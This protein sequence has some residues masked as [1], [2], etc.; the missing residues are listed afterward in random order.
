M[1]PRRSALAAVPVGVLVTMT[2]CGGG[3]EAGRAATTSLPPVATT[4]RSATT[5]RAHPST[6]PPRPTS[7]TTASRLSAA[8]RLGFEGVGPGRLG[9][10]V[11]EA[12]R[13][14]GVPMRVKGG[15]YC[16]VVE[17][18]GDPVGVHFIVTQGERLDVIEVD[19]GPIA[20]QAGVRAGSTEDEA[21]RAHPGIEVVNPGEPVHRLV[22]RSPDRARSIVFAIVEG[23][24]ASFRVGAREVAEADEICA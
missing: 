10:T 19:Q 11:E 24:V 20:T 5:T 7:P 18:E 6:S 22:L 14:A 17:P 15:P 8:S 13:A 23:R 16:R 1:G 4:A 2:A 9:V 3:R 12:R 21:R